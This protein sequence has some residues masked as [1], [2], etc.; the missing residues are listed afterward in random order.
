M[1][2]ILTRKNCKK[3]KNILVRESPSKIIV[4]IHFIERALYLDTLFTNSES[5]AET[6][7]L[8]KKTLKYQTEQKR[9]REAPM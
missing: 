9:Q 7:A 5:E 6:R 4:V 2:H 1:N 3:T 8:S